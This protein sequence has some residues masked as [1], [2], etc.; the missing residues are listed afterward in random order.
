[1]PVTRAVFFD[2]GG[3]L[4]HLDHDFILSCLADRGL[5]RDRAAFAAA[6]RRGRVAMKTI[7]QSSEP[8]DDAARWR[9]YAEAMLRHLGCEGEDAIAVRKRIGEHN[10]AG[11]LWA[12]AEPGTL[13]TLDQLKRAGYIVGIVSNSDGR[14]HQ[15]LEYAGLAGSLDFV[16]DSGAVGIEKPDRR[17]FDIACERAGVDPSEVVHVGDL[18]EIDIVGARSA[19]IE[20]VLIDPSDLHTGEDCTRIRAIPDM[21][22]LLQQRVVP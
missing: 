9:A 17:I 20:G 5:V 10:K 11:R 12:H 6:D 4:L 19:G 14:V 8:G 3:T 21:I 1:M 16:V 22:P 2:V 7:L 18:Y 15:F 13:A